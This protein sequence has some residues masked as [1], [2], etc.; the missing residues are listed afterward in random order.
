MA[1]LVNLD[2]LIEE[3]RHAPPA[4]AEEVR[5]NRLRAYTGDL[6]NVQKLIAR[7]QSPSARCRYRAEA[8]RL[9]GLIKEMTK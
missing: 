1:K 5:A 7:T 9:M 6:K 4:T 3:I 8:K 2:A